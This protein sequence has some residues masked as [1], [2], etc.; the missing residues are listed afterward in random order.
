MKKYYKSSDN[1]ID[2]DKTHNIYISNIKQ[3]LQ[4]NKSLIVDTVGY[5]KN[6]REDLRELADVYDAQA[7]V[8]YVN[9]PLRIVKQRWVQK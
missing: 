7:Y 5:N 8:I 9:T 2:W 6:G 4:Q 3:A 1:E